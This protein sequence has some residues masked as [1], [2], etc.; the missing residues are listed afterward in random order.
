MA[1]RI[2]NNNGKDFSRGYLAS[3]ICLG[4]VG[5]IGLIMKITS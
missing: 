1:K 3:G 5:Y 4:C 2:N